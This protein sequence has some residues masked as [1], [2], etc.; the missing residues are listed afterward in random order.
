MT[1]HPTDVHIGHRIRHCR[2]L[3]GFTQKQLAS[4]VG[5]KFQQIRKYES[6]ANR[7]SASRLWDIANTM[8]VPVVWFF[9]GLEDGAEGTPPEP[10]ADDVK[11][12]SCINRLRTD[13]RRSL[14]NLLDALESSN[15]VKGAVG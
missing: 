11:V 8:A 7:C 4:A 1:N 6:G 9:E 15:A 3:K 10:S 12:A 14:V 2:W 13:Q 5:I